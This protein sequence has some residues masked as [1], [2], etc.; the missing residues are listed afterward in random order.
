MANFVKILAASAATAAL[1]TATPAFAQDDTGWSGEA[2]LTGSK[3]TGNTETTDIGLGLKLNKQGTTW[4]HS[5]NASA[6]FGRVSGET[7][8]ERYVLG[9]QIDRNLSDRLYA[10]G[11]ADYYRDE[12]GAFE[13]GYYVGAGLGYK[14]VEPA[15]L[16][17]D[18]EGGVGYRSQLPAVAAGLTPA[19]IAVLE[20]DGSL[21]RQ[22]ELALRGASKLT[23][24]FN[25]AVSL[26]NNS[27]VTWSESDTYLWNEFGLTAN[28]M[29]NLAARA[30]FRVDHHTDVLPG[31]EKT[32]TITRFGV[33]Y[34]MD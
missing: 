24:D 9:Y 25:D 17:W 32:D 15:P 31:R 11:N 7:N 2:S 34:T 4:G 27:E 5:F 14:L 33:V 22:N 16:G 12:F 18:I 26:Y 1:L 30:S 8:K 28:L 20:A 29:G 6:D 19:E 21:D 13:E 10:L 3:T 23:Y